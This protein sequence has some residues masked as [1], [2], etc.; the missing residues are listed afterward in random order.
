MKYRMYSFVL[1]Q[2]TTMQK[3]IQTTHAVAQLLGTN[4]ISGNE[5]QQW[6]CKDATLIMLD[7][8]IYQELQEVINTLCNNNIAHSV[9]KEEDLNDLETAVA[10]LAD[11]RVWDRTNYPDFDTWVRT[12][13][14]YLVEVCAGY[15]TSSYLT[16]DPEK[17][18]QAKNEW[19][20]F[21]GGPTNAA[22]RDLIFSKRLAI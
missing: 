19:V 13:D 1:R 18:E 20:S 10:V 15:N 21:I 4:M 12:Q 11:E 17:L 6:A 16:N 2:L 8:G 22:L 7:G 9:F 14:E 3:G 5:Y